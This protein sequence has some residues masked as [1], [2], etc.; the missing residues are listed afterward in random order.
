MDPTGGE[1]MDKL[2]WSMP[3]FKEA[4]EKNDVKAIHRVFKD[5]LR[6][7]ETITPHITH[8]EFRKIA[9]ERIV[10]YSSLVTCIHQGKCGYQDHFHYMCGCVN[11]MKTVFTLLSD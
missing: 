10:A 7:L 4:V 11:P 8:P 1:I 3:V 5:N 2:I 6:L 9:A